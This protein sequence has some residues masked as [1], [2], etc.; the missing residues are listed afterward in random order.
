MVVLGGER[1]RQIRKIR[2]NRIIIS[3]KVD[4]KKKTSAV[5]DKKI[6]G[7]SAQ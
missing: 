4:Y 2:T 5:W 6:P 1:M 3:L 7:K